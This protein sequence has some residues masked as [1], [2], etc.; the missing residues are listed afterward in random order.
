MLTHEAIWRA[1]DQLARHNS[2]SAS[3]LAKRA[4]LDPTTFNPSKRTTSDGRKRWPSTES[5]SKILDATGASLGSFVA[6]A[7]GEDPPPSDGASRIPILGYAQAGAEGFFDD[8]G[9]PVGT[10]WDEIV[11]PEVGDGAVYA[12]E[13][14]G[15]SME[16]VYRDG[17]LIIVS[18]SASLRRG[19][20]VVVRTEG[21][22]VM[23]KELA[24]MSATK[25]ELSSLNTNH[26]QRSLPRTEISWMARILWASQ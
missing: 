17:D 25:V 15:D 9:F 22:E 19:D 5:I 7:T 4:G 1:I 2:L 6:L 20:R 8:A 10:G 18:P 24:R 21:G 26:P 23:A 12:L 11:F 3:G 14:S 13:V 16:P